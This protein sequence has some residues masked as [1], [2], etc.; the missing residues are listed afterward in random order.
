MLPFAS[1]SYCYHGFDDEP[2]HQ[3]KSGQRQHLSIL[4]AAD[5]AIL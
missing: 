1:F 2:S 5:A 4:F 3:A